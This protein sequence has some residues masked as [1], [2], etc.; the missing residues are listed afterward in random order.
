MDDGASA[1]GDRLQ[2]FQFVLHWRQ[3]LFAAEEKFGGISW[4][5]NKLHVI[6]EEYR[7]LMRQ[8]VVINNPSPFKRCSAFAMAFMGNYPIY[9]EFKNYKFE[10]DLKNV[11]RYSG[12]VLVYEYV[13]F[14]LH[15]AVLEKE[16]GKKD[17]L[18][19]PI[20]VSKHSFI[21]IIHAL[22]FLPAKGATS[23]GS[24]FHLL[25]LLFEQLAY[26]TNNVSYSRDI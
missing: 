13:R 6:P 12:A 20:L 4:S 10:N 21:D 1:A 18:T 2:V 3:M 26:Q 19:N 7:A 24:S 15:G 25:A 11:P 16:D 8:Y 14:C 23:E 17:I 22:A 5:L 9:G